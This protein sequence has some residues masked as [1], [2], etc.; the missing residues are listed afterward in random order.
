MQPG[1][2]KR[3]QAA[4]QSHTGAFAGDLA[5]AHTLL[6]HAGVAVV[7]GL[8]ALVDVALLLA[9]RPIPPA[10]RTAFMTNSGAVRGLAFDFAHKA[11]L[12]LAEWSP[13]TAAG[14]RQI[15]PPFVA[16]DNPLDIGT[17]AFA[18]PELMKRAAQL[19]IDDASVNSLIL[20]LFTG[21]PPQ[22]VEKAEQLLPV[23]RASPKP[24]A[25]VMLG[26]PMPLDDTFTRMVREEGAALFR[27]TERAVR[28]MAAVNAVSRALA[29]DRAADGAGKRLNLRHLPA[30][31]VAE[32][33]AK[34]LLAGAGVPVP[35]GGFAK[36]L[37]AAEDI[38]ARIGFPVALKAQAAE[39]VH[40]SDAG[41]VMLNVGDAMALREA[42]VQL[43]EDVRR[44][45]PGLALDGVLV[46]AMAD[47]GLEL[48]V[49]AR[50]DPQ[51]GAV[52]MLGLGG[53][54]VE[55][56]K[57]VLLVPTGAGQ[58]AIVEAL[59]RLKGVALMRGS[60]GSAPVDIAA[61]ADIA[62]TVGGLMQGSPE[63]AELEINPLVVYPEG[64]GALALDALIVRSAA[65]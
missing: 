5:V 34:E 48:I 56:L 64:E 13:A 41:A 43:N 21:R 14:L 49:G 65:S 4:A 39:L 45:R 61:V 20:S 63:I 40:K 19:L 36:D 59:G 1:R 24:V 15:F 16:I 22:Q 23:I 30:G 60:R 51:W 38:A 31:P 37:A 32:Y 58:G 6:A 44:A 11:G 29:R 10:G 12:E 28:A 18:R 7:D 55:T 26:D 42:W 50:R 54:W 33:R 53:I 9:T 25:F 3:A 8:D 62:N 2:T 35:T 52:L 17:I 47:K 46:E 27:S 57:D